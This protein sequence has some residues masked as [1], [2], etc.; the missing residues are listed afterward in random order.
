MAMSVFNISPGDSS[1]PPGLQI[2]AAGNQKAMERRFSLLNAVK[3]RD[4][5]NFNQQYQHRLGASPL[6]TL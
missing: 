4:S 5:F 3:L 6:L 2:T 1:V